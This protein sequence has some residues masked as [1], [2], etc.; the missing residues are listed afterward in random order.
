MGNEERSEEEKGIKE[1]KV[2]GKG[3]ADKGNWQREEMRKLRKVERGN[4]PHALT[5]PRAFPKRHE[6]PLKTRVLDPAL[7]MEFCGRGED[8]WVEEDVVGGHGDWC[9]WFRI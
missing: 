7:R 4:A 9:L 6:I 3:E 1:E 5:H 2:K 8:A